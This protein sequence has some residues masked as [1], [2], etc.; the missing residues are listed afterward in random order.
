[1][2][3]NLFRVLIGYLAPIVPTLADKSAAF[4]GTEI[5]TA[6]SWNASTEP[7]LSHQIEPFKHLMKRIDPKAVAK[8]VEATIA[9]TPADDASD[10]TATTEPIA[11]TITIDEFQKID[12]RVAR[13]DSAAYV[14][15][16]DKLLE[17][18]L[19]LGAGKRTVF[20]GIKSAY[21]PQQL[22]GRM[23]VV[24]ANLAVRKLR[25][26]TS[27]GMVLCAGSGDN[28]LWLLAPDTG[29]QP[30]MRIS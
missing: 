4:L 21:E 3:L 18:S 11:D 16:S 9:E 20:A 28:E 17:L 23:V 14:E 15:G 30:G 2:G 22:D 29:A 24:V 26:G 25:F 8:V 13:I 6:G 19:D 12:L 1:M 10:D 5:G 27:E 7:L